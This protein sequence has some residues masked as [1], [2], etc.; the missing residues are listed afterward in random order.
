MSISDKIRILCIR[1]GITMRELSLR[2]GMSPQ[3][4]SGKLKRESF[5]YQE[6]EAMAQ[7][8]GC[9]FRMEFVLPDGDTV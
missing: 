5:S 4:F 2:M 8:A 1:R 3:N 6:L 7:A 9:Q